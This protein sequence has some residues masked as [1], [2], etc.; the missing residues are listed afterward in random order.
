[1]LHAPGIDASSA[2]AAEREPGGDDHKWGR[3]LGWASSDRQQ[4]IHIL[5][6]PVVSM[7]V[8]GFKQSR[9]FARR[10]QYIVNVPEV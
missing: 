6:H 9:I 5:Q 8:Y 7:A 10:R 3:S 4:Q 1:M 2:E